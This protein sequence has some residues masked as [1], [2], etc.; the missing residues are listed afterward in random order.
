MNEEIINLLR[1]IGYRFLG[2]NHSAIKICTWTRNAIRGK[3]VCYKQKF[4]GI[5]SNRCIQMSPAIF[6]CTHRCLFCWRNTNITYPKW[7][8]PVDEPDVIMDEAIAAQKE[9]L[10]G[11]GGNETANKRKFY[12][13]LHPKH[14]AI[15]L[16]GEPLLYPKISE[17]INEVKN[18]GMTAFVVTNG[19]L[20]EVLEK[21]AEPTQLYITLPAPD[22]EIYEK[23]CQPLI[24][25]GWEKLNESLS[26]LSNFS[27]NTVLRL[28]LVKDLNMIHPEQ[29]AKIIDK[30][31]SKFVEVKSF[32]SVGFS[33]ERIAYEKMPLHNEI[34]EFAKKIA[35]E[36]GYKIVDEQKE[37]RVVLLRR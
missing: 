29:Y 17:L 16:A 3:G 19:T 7:I 32:M 27:C 15:S 25:K 31:N 34:Q 36:S 4:Y 9:I 28:T 12:D 8:G 24:V 5:E 30:S 6:N 37:S 18:R 14:V 21:M 22:K 1:K 20:P 23:T 13:A 26:L 33:R 11:F 10:M 2:S 35:E